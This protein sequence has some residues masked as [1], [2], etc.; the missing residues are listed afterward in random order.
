MASKG[1][2]P[3][4]VRRMQQE[5]FEVLG[6]ARCR[7]ELPFSRHL[8]R[9]HHLHWAILSSQYTILAQ[10]PSRFISMEFMQATAQVEHLPIKS[11][12]AHP[13]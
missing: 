6:Q 8:H 7:E 2:T 10:A 5:L 12:A 1:D 9:H 4:Y 11:R 13:M 3:E